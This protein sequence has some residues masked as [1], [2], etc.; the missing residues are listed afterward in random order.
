VPIPIALRVTRSL[1]VHLVNTGVF[2]IDPCFRFQAGLRSVAS[3]FECNPAQVKFRLTHRA[4]IR[5]SRGR[6]QRQKREEP[7]YEDE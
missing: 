3:A 4:M 2:H 1:K 6:E 7:R 5:Y